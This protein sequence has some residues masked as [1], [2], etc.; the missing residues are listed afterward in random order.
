MEGKDLNITLII[1]IIT[2]NK[3][4]NINIKKMNLTEF[5]RK[6]QNARKIFGKREIDIIEKQVNGISLTQS[7]K[8]RLSRDVR[9]KFEFIKEINRYDFDFELKKG[10]EIKKIINETKEQILNSAFRGVEEIVLFGSAVENKLTFRSDIDIAVKF[11]KID[12]REATKFRAFI[13]GRVNK[14]VDIQVY[15]V[16][17]EKIKKEIGSKGKTVWKIRE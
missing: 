14:K 11:K 9:K 15:N 5:L 17:E 7:E 10:S 8:N 1:V 3:V 16:L 12:V 2:F 13:S 4:I 6:D